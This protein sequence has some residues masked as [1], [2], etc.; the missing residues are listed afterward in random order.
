MGQMIESGASA[1]Q[2]MEILDI[3]SKINKISSFTGKMNSL[4][5]ISGSAGLGRN[6]ASIAKTRAD[7][8]EIG[9]IAEKGVKPDMDISRIL[10]NSFV[11]QNLNIFNEITNEL[12]PVTFLTATDGFTE[13]YNKLKK[14]LGTE[15]NK[16][17]E[18][19][20][21]KIKNDMLSEVE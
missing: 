14:S 17:T 10:E 8:V 9:A 21:Q 13:F 20:E 5:G 4:T 18:E 1:Q 11:K 19:T 15:S 6:F 2:E 16:F 3:I 7:L 12:L